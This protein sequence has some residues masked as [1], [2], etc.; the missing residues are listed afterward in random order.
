M[1]GD[2]PGRR[3]KVINE[4]LLVSSIR[5]HELTEEAQRAL[6]ALRESEERL[7]FV[8][9]SAPQMFFTAV[10]G[11]D[12]DYFNSQWMD[13]TGLS[14]AKL[15]GWGWR[16]AIHPEDL[17]ENVR[18]WQHSLDTGESFYFEHRLRRADGEYR[19]HVTRAHAMRDEKKRILMWV[20]SNTDIQSQKE[21]EEELEVRVNERTADLEKANQEMEGFTYTVAHDLRAP[22]RAIVSNSRML[23]QELE[24]KLSPEHTKMLNRQAFNANKLAAIIDELLKYSRLVRQQ[25]VR[26]IFDLS[27][28]ARVIAAELLQEYPA[29]A[30]FDIQNGMVASADPQLVQFLMTNLMENACKFSPNGGKIKVGVKNEK[31]VEV[32]FVRDKGIG[33]HM[34]YAHKVFQ[35]FERLVTEDE[36]PGTGI[37]LA[38]VQ[39]IVTRHGGRVWVESKVGKG[40]TFYFTLE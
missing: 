35:P 9:D 23:A 36:F 25:L 3:L 32:F 26:S 37:G 6:V 7:R 20:G 10:P 19:W 38:N 13:Y 27:Q 14:F 33:F 5:Q 11:G 28:M 24:S 30:T 18:L 2:E 12:V 40:T 4:A 29:S 21:Q 31:G 34:D 22:L 16:R 8:M 1:P 39:R 17:D 15:R